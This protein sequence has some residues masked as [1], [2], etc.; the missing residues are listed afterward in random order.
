MVLLIGNGVF[1]TLG[2]SGL[3]FVLDGWASSFGLRCAAVYSSF[4]GPYALGLPIA[5]MLLATHVAPMLRRSKAILIAVLAELG[6]SALFG[7]I[8]FL[9]AF[10]SDLGSARATVE[11]LLWRSVWL[12]FLVV[13]CIVAL[14]LYQGLYPAPK[15]QTQPSAGFQPYRPPTYG[16][17]YPGQPMY[18]Q[19]TYAPGT[20]APSYGPSETITDNAGWPIIPPPPQPAPLIVASSEPTTRIA[21]QTVDIGGDA[22]QKV[23]EPPER[24][25]PGTQVIELS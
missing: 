1:L 10:A 4:V 8:T 2:F 12:G 13:A 23:P 25:E 19:P 20:A 5:A 11:G 9:G 16:S 24:S 15:P 3:F 6:V 14:R 17:P 7:A 21:P 22:T 18:P